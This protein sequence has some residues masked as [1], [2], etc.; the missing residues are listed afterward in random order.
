MAI[1]ALD[2]VSPTLPDDDQ[3]W[4]APS[5]SV[6]G[7]VTLEP[8]A[9]VW[10]GAVLRGDNE[11]ILIGERSNIQDNCVLHTDMGFPLSVGRRVTVGHQ[12]TLHGCTIGHGALIGMGATVLNGA[13]IGCNVV[14]G[15]HALVPE[16][17]EIPD[18]SLVVGI[19]GRVVR[20]LPDEEAA[21]LADLAELYVNRLNSY[22]SR[23]EQVG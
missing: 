15:A 20:T 23:F 10:F 19:P 18:N 12:A 16:G 6:I 2:G 4:I 3:Y 8:F 17:K 22:N 9:S 13:N 5:A 21:T 1:Y 7:K 11:R 14:I